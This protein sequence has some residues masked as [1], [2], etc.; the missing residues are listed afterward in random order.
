MLDMRWTAPPIPWSDLKI[1]YICCGP[2]GDQTGLLGKNEL[3]EA[4]T[5]I[6]GL[7]DEA[8]YQKVPTKSNMEDFGWPIPVAALTPVE[9]MCMVEFSP[10]GLPALDVE[11]VEIVTPVRIAVA[12][13]QIGKS[14]HR[15]SRIEDPDLF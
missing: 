13:P 11:I 10:G 4:M 15:P 7:I 9:S 8:R 1:V 3:H 2:P 5:S 12:L 14:R 6:I